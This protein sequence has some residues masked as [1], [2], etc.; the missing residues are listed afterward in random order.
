MGARWVVPLRH[1]TFAGDLAR[2]AKWIA[3]GRNVNEG[4]ATMGRPEPVN[5]NE[6]VGSGI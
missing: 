3:R 2:L 1:A 5:E 4:I 6:T